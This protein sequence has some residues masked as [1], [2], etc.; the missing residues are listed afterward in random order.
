MNLTKKEHET[1]MLLHK[2]QIEKLDRLKGN[3][4]VDLT[5]SRP[6]VQCSQNE[7]S[8]LPVINWLND[9]TCMLKTG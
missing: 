2:K 9:G 7:L 4:S 1:K 5:T 3:E 8:L 6:K